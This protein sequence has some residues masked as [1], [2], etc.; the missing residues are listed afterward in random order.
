MADSE[1]RDEQNLEKSIG[2]EIVAKEVYLERA[3]EAKDPEVKALFK[4]VA[5]DEEQHEQQL[6][7]LLKKDDGKNYPVA[8]CGF[9]VSQLIDQAADDLRDNT[10]V[11]H[12]LNL[13]DNRCGLKLEKTRAVVAELAE[14]ART[15]GQDE[16]QLE[17]VITAVREDFEAEDRV[18]R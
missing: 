17:K 9:A 4:E 15:K 12:W 10:M 16:K 11:N 6:E 13:V 5:A 1:T 3:A 7:V 8:D 2:E 18:R 14:T